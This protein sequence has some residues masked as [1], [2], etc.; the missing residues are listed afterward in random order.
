MRTR[1]NGRHALSQ[2]FLDA[3]ERA[4][5]AI[6]NGFDPDFAIA[7]CA[8]RHG[9]NAHELAVYLYPEPRLYE[10]PARPRARYLRRAR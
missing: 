4:T 1:R 9:V 3:V 8:I 2:D 6:D 10:V 7:G 5:R